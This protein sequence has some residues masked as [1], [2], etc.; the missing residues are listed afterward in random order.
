MDIIPK[1]KEDGGRMAVSY[2]LAMYHLYPLQLSL[3][4][5]CLSQLPF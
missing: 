3:M 4:I 5:V 1:G 2:S